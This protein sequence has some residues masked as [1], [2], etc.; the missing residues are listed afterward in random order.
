MHIHAFAKL[1]HFTGNGG[2]DET[3]GS[4]FRDVTQSVRS[5]LLKTH[6]KQ[7]ISS[8]VEIPL[9]EITYSYAT[10]RGNLREGTKFFFSSYMPQDSFELEVMAEGK[11]MQWVDSFNFDNPHRRIGNVEIL[12]VRLVAA[13]KLSLSA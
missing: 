3:F 12:S 7:F 1:C 13:S 6:P 5:L 9:Y 4:F 11:L 8:D 10:N 2:T